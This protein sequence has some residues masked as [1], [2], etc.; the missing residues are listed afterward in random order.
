M[1]KM[2]LNFRDLYDLMRFVTKTKKDN[3]VIDC[4]GVVYAEIKTELSVPN[5]P[6]AIC[7]QNQIG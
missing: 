1:P 4:I 5:E 3:D 6:S 7:Y 2:I